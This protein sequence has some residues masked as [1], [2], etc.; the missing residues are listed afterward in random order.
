MRALARP[1][2]TGAATTTARRR[3]RARKP[4]HRAVTTADIHDPPTSRRQRLGANEG[5]RY[6]RRCGGNA[7]AITQ[8]DADGRPARAPCANGAQRASIGR[9]AHT[10]AGR[11]AQ[12]PTRAGPAA[13]DCRN[14]KRHSARE[15][16][17]AR[18]SS[19]EDRSRRGENERR[20]RQRPTASTR[21]S[22][23]APQRQCAAPSPPERRDATHERRRP[24]SRAAFVF[25]QRAR[26]LTPIRSSPAVCR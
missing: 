19:R 5:E 22:I 11:R 14:A 7:L 16:T 15:R 4:M 2:G 23:E 25:A 13:G 8:R 18:T 12:A 10:F 1:A 9:R 24:R 17:G 21:R 3:E 6:A 20:Q 26:R